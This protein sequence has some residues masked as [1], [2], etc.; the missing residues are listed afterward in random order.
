MAPF[1]GTASS[2][3]VPERRWY[4]PALNASSESEAMRAEPFDDEK[5]T[6]TVAEEGKVLKVLE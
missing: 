5:V 2:V 1:V 6:E 3:L 4:L